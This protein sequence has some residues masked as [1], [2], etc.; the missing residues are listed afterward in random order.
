MRNLVGLSRW[1]M[2]AC[3]AMVLAGCGGES[4][5]EGLVEQQLEAAADGEVDADI[6]LETGEFRIETEDGSF[7]SG[8]GAELPA[9]FPADVPLPVGSLV[10]TFVDEQADGQ[11]FGLTFQ[12]DQPIAAVYDTWK[13]VVETAGYEQIFESIDDAATSGQFEGEAW[14]LLL[15]GGDDGDGA[16]FQL[17]VVPIDE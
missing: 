16:F 14:R 12:S 9:D 15:T 2:A 10:A 1:T 4:I 11:T 13:T 8:S 6:D 3:G 5:T 17:S 7:V